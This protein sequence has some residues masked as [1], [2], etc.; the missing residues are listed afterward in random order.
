MNVYSKEQIDSKFGSSVDSTPTQN[1][2]NLV[3]SGGVY[4]A[5]NTAVPS[6]SGASVGDV[7]TV[8][9][10]GAEW[11]TPSGGGVTK[12]E[13]IDLTSLI[14]AISTANIGDIIVSRHLQ[15]GSIHYYN[16][17]IKCVYKNQNNNET[18]RFI[19]I[20]GDSSDMRIVLWE[21]NPSNS[22][23]S[24]RYTTFT[25]GQYPSTTSTT[26][27]TST[28]VGAEYCYLIHYN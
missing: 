26:I 15:C 9:S 25:N 20:C 3:T 7:L 17:E 21:Y 24:C 5:I 27:T 4:S 6:T 18:S 19:G 28:T 13:I 14:N 10:S 1:S 12:T 22:N 2:T 11:S 16:V 8:G 23:I